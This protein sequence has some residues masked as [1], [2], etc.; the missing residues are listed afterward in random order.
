MIRARYR[1]PRYARQRYARPRHGRRYG[2]QRFGRPR[3]ARQRYARDRARGDHDAGDHGKGCPFLSARAP[4]A[5]LC[6]RAR[7]A[8]LVRDAAEELS[9]R[10]AALWFSA[11]LPRRLRPGKL[12]MRIRIPTFGHGSPIPG[13]AAAAPTSKCIDFTSDARL[14]GGCPRA[15]DQATFVAD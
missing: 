12:F 5:R 6:P 13:G 15:R 11:R 10:I 2:R 4:A 9:M 8:P 14:C 7:V 1:R 3:Y